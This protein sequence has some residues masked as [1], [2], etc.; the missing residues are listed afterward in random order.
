M[1]RAKRQ[2][3]ILTA[4]AGLAGAGTVLVAG[5]AWRPAGD[6]DVVE[7]QLPP[8]VEVVNQQEQ[9][10]PAVRF[11]TL[12]PG[13]TLPAEEQCTAM[14]QRSSWEP[15]PANIVAN[16]TP[17]VPLLGGGVPGVD[18]ARV[19][20]AFSGTTDEILRWAA[21]KWGFDEDTVRA[22]AV[23]ESSWRQ[24][25]VG[26]GGLSFGIMQVKRTAHPGTF[27]LARDS[28]A[29][30]VDYALAWRRA[31]YDGNFSWLNGPSKRGGYQRGDEWGCIGAWF[32]GDWYDDGARDYIQRVRGHHI[33][34][35]WL[36]PGF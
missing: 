12:P 13:S 5:L 29:F 24:A 7:A 4:V 27:P 31:C 19:T 25:M 28:T 33:A 20:G 17:G 34:K 9:G 14:L 1:S 15:R 3:W 10:P 21:C 2:R 8:A 6:G 30:N 11:A 36:R 18:A 22:V 16:A 32:S 26:D 35:P 23:Q